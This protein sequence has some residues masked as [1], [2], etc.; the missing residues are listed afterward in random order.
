LSDD[1]E[2]VWQ[3][4]K[5]L[6]AIAEEMGFAQRYEPHRLFKAREYRAAVIAA[7]TLLESKL[8]ERL[9]KAS[10]E[11]VRRPIS[12]RQILEMAVKEE[13]LQDRYQDVLTWM[14][15]RNHVVHDGG[16]VSRQEAEA[17]VEG[18]DQIIDGI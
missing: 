7:M 16:R 4:A 8:R 18:V 9:N 13:I 14:K 15:L 5:K 17:V 12:M 1:D 10:L 2:F 6:D 3:L 11:V